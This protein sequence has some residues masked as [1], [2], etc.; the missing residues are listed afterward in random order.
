ML[1]TWNFRKNSSLE[2]LLLLNIHLVR[3]FFLSQYGGLCS[4]VYLLDFFLFKLFPF[5]L[6][7][8]NS[9]VSY[10][11]LLVIYIVFFDRLQ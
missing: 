4:L 9:I 8:Y 2:I 1:R 10:H 3:V 7:E 6:F 5:L 11:A